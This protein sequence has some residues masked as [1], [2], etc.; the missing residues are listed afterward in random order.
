MAA[1]E[2]ESEVDPRITGRQALLA[3]VRSVRAMVPCAMKMGADRLRH[4]ASLR[5]T[6]GCWN[7]RTGDR[8][9]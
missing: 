6:G 8:R 7:R 2:T 9:R 4:L 5:Y 3:A 1:L